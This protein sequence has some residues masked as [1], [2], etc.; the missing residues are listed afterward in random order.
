MGGTLSRTPARQVRVA[1]PRQAFTARSDEV[2]DEFLKRVCGA[3]EA[4]TL[5]AVTLDC[6]RSGYSDTVVDRV[7]EAAGGKLVLQL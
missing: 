4:G 6:R 1:G 3:R 2:T 7:Q 5:R